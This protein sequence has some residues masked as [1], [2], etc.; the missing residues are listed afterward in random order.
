MVMEKKI[1][2]LFLNAGPFALDRRLKKDKY[3]YLSKYFIGDLITPVNNA[4]KEITN[5]K[6]VTLDGFILRPLP[7]YYSGSAIK[8]NLLSFIAVIVRALKIYYRGDKFQIVIASNPLIAG[9]SAILIA[10]ITGAKAIV[11][12]N[13]CFESAF[14]C[15]EAGEKKISA[16]S[17][18]KEKLAH[19]IIGFVL[20][21]ADMV[22]LLYDEQL[23]PL[24]FPFG[25]KIKKVSF[26]DFVPVNAFY[27]QKIED[28]K[29][30]LLVGYPWYLK[31]VDI[32][33]K[34]FLKISDQFP[35][36]RLKVVGWCPEGREYFEEIADHNKKVELCNA[37]P[38]NEIVTLMASCSVY[39]LASRTEAMGR[40][41]IEAMACRKPII[42]S[43]VGGVRS[44]VKNGFN[45][46]FFEKEDVNGLADKLKELLL[47]Q[48]M[49]SNLGNNGFV[50]V[51]DKLSEECYLKE[52]KAMVEKTLGV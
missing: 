35:G 12:V 36:Y 45:G 30:I 38:Y 17:L 23:L 47:N 13:G 31:G 5:K 24:N 37:V 6:D 26:S 1:R 48:E 29:Y 7:Y 19:R 51:K 10:R 44:I 3:F 42:A 25:K 32:L 4:T 2:L 20:K 27:G 21:R 43:N 22:R 9:L 46:L 50:F 52:F 33:I 41:L 18:M 15:G 28:K 39:V 40:V 11:E 34:A 16:G 49:A 14:R 8:R